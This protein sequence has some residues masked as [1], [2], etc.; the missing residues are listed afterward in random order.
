MPGALVPSIG[1]YLAAVLFI[2]L[3]A[4]PAQGQVASGEITG[5]VDDQAGTGIPGAVITV[6][7][8]ATNGRRVTTTSGDGVYTAPGL[9][10]GVYRVD[11]ELTGF[12][13][14]R[15]EGVHITTGGKARLDITLALGTI[16]E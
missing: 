1:R 16:Q 6:T 13:A 2:V 11:V 10:P 5:H 8:V 15:R 3:A 12:K 7:S 14:V 4:P 9:A